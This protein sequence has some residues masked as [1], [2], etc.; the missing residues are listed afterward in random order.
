[1]HYSVFI[2]SCIVSNYA[3][4]LL[5]IS[6][7]QLGASSSVTG[8]MSTK[9]TL[10]DQQ[11]QSGKYMTYI[12]LLSLIRLLNTEYVN[13]LTIMFPLLQVKPPQR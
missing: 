11:Q 3:C 8:D 9:M 5:I 12:A 6:P 1:M 13:Y 4:S 10:S 7:T 2:V